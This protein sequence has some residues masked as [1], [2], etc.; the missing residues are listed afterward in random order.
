M[1]TNKTLKYSMEMWPGGATPSFN[2]LSFTDITV[3]LSFEHG[4]EYKQLRR[5]QYLKAEK[6]TISI[7]L[8]PDLDQMAEKEWLFTELTAK[9]LVIVA[10]VFQMKQLVRVV[11]HPDL[12]IRLNENPSV[13]HLRELVQKMT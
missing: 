6:L 4:I 11:K 13:T 12:H 9:T 1:N 2:E 3:M 7:I 8:L 5:L 10:D